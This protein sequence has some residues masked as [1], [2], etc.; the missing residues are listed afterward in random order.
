MEEKLVYLLFCR[1][2]DDI[3]VKVFAKEEDA[4][5]TLESERKFY[6][7]EDDCIVVGEENCDMFSV[8]YV[9]EE[10]KATLTPQELMDR[11]DTCFWVEAAPFFDVGLRVGLNVKEED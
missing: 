2:I 3:N 4:L 6:L 11:D 10:E 8:Y 7:N 5:A 9:D 1:D